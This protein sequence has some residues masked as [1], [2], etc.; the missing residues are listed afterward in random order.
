MTKTKFALHY[1]ALNACAL[2][3]L[4]LAGCGSSDTVSRTTTTE[5]TT[6]QLAP[7]ATTTTTTEQTR[8]SH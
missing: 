8:Q 4:L 5:Q 2:G 6:T 1:L 7:V 3:M